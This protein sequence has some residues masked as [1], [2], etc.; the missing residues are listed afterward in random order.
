MEFSE[1]MFHQKQNPK[2][3]LNNYKKKTI[4]KKTI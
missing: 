2:V 1:F 3:K 4:K